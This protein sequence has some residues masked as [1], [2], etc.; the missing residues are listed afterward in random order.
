MCECSGAE[1]SDE[2]K[3]KV[4]SINKDIDQDSKC[5]SCQTISCDIFL[6]LPSNIKEN[7]ATLL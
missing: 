3:T 6:D 2:L 7:K 4:A 1:S 5:L